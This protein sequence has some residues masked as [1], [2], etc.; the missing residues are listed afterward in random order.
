ML[1][2]AETPVGRK[3]PLSYRLRIEHETHLP[4]VQDPPRAYPRLF[5]PHENPWRPC[6]HQRTPRQRPQAFGRLS[7]HRL[8]FAPLLAHLLSKAQF[9]AVFA[10]RTISKSPHFALHF[11]AEQT[12]AI[13]AVV[14]KRWARSAV[15]RNTI[16]RQVYA[17]S[18]TQSSNLSV[19]H[20]VVRLRAEFSRKEFPSA[21]SDV[22]KRAV[23]SEL[24]SL[25]SKVAL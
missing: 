13:G 14:P 2:F 17:V 19:G 9:D 23:R 10:G 11:M 18:E 20:Y 21:T 15:T 5:S 4:T 22:L 8:S 16:K 3:R 12:R 6:C 25:F 1:G 7:Q 24:T